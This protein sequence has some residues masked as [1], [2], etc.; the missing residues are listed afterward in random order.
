MKSIEVAT[1]SDDGSHKMAENFVRV[2]EGIVEASKKFG[3]G[4]ATVQTWKERLEKAGFTNVRQEVYKVSDSP[5][6]FNRNVAHISDIAA[7]EPL[8]R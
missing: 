2:H 8:A 5:R 4:M 1:S 3:K 6:T 7:T